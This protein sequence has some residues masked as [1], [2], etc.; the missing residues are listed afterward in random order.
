M[1]AVWHRLTVEEAEAGLGA[2]DV[3]AVR[4]WFLEERRLMLGC[5]LVKITVVCQSAGNSQIGDF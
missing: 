1:A 5:Q 2:A 4:Q 3:L